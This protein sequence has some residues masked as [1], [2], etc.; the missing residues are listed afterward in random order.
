[1]SQL[2]IEFWPNFMRLALATI[3][4][5]AG[6]FEK[7]LN[8]GYLNPS[9][10]SYVGITIEVLMQGPIMRPFLENVVLPHVLLVGELVMIGEISFGILNLLGLMTRFTNTVAF[11]TNLIYF[12]SAYW[13]DTE[14]YGINLLM[15]II[16]LYL[17]YK[18]AQDFGLDALVRGKFK[19]IEDP[20]IWFIAGTV[21]YVGII[22]FLLFT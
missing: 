7:L 6:V 5:Y 3:W 2:K 22:L 1:M 10:T 8:P 19:K 13:V 11:Y 14:E 16:E 4:I 17:I 9:S 20:K 12:L 21:F 18:G 15:M